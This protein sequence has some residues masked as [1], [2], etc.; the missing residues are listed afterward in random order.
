MDL[1]QLPSAVRLIDS[2]GLTCDPDTGAIVAGVVPKSLA[3][4]DLRPPPPDEVED[5]YRPSPGL[6]RLVRLRDG[7]CR[8]PGCQVN[9]RSCD[10]DHV[11]AWPAGATTTSNLMCLCR[12]HHRVKQRPGWTARLD[13]DGVVHWT[14]PSQRSTDTQPVDHLDRVHTPREQ[15]DPTPPST[16]P[17]AAT[18]TTATAGVRLPI[19]PAQIHTL[20]ELSL[21]RLLDLAQTA[22]RRPPTMRLDWVTDPAHGRHLLVDLPA[23]APPAPAVEDPPF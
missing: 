1:D 5:R 11:I 9:A 17:T 4:C 14:D 12:R 13:P 21:D 18:T 8:F 2:T 10:I 23:E 15:P 20:L 16:A 3:P 19:D 6:Q 22:T 7:H